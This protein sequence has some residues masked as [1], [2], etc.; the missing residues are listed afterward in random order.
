MKKIVF[1]S[2]SYTHLDLYKRQ[3]IYKGKLTFVYKIHS[4][5]NPFVLPVEGGKFELPFTCKKQVYLNECFIAVSYTHLDVYKRQ[6]QFKKGGP[7]FYTDQSPLHKGEYNVSGVIAP[8]WNGHV[9]GCL[10][11][12]SR[13][14]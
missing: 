2:V 4:E 14:V 8:L 10:L 13:C 5:Q 11:Y 1:V 6:L 12:T 7:F 3:I 9:Y